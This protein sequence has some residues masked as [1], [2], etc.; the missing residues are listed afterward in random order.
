MTELTSEQWDNLSSIDLNSI[1]KY[2][3]ESYK[4]VNKSTSSFG[5]FIYIQ[6]IPDDGKKYNLFL[7]LKNKRLDFHMLG[8][9]N[10][11]I[12]YSDIEIL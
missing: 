10:V 9:F 8:S 5:N 6:K 3:D 1:I 12:S 11:T 4:V 7:I 2:K